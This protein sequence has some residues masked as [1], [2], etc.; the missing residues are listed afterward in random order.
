MVQLGQEKMPQGLWT[1]NSKKEKR[2]RKEFHGVL[3]KGSPSAF[4]HC[5]WEC[6]MLSVSLRHF[7]IKL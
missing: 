1:P 7:S 3:R 6:Q 4:Q 2:R 5:N